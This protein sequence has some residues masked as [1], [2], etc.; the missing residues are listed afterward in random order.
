MDG[1]L[2]INLIASDPQVRNGRPFIVGT[3]VT[4]ADVVIAHVYQR[5]DADGIAAWYGLSLAQT[6]AALAWYYDH[7]AETDELVHSLIRKADTLTDERPGNER[8]LLPR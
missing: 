8:S 5:L 3:T 6:H 7:K 4:V 1:I 2:S